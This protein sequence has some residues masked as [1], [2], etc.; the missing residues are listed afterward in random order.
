MLK[1]QPDVLLRTELNLK[2]LT[3][4]SVAWSNGSYVIDASVY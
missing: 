2:G 3:V 1:I 4:A